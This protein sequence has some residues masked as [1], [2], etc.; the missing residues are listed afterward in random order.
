[1]GFTAY[2]FTAHVYYLGGAPIAQSD[3][4]IVKLLLKLS[5]LSKISTVFL[6]LLISGD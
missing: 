2:A 3:M 5:F 6:L 1:M 4:C